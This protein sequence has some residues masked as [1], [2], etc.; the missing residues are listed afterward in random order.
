MAQFKSG[1]GIARTASCED[2]D[3]AL[4][5]ATNTLPIR[6]RNLPVGCTESVVAA[7]VKLPDLGVQALP[8]PFTLL[9]ENTYRCEGNTGLS[10]EI[11][12]DGLGLVTT[13]PDGWQR[14]ATP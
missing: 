3:L 12:A 8:Q 7:W 4:T 1:A 14:I 2:A 5:P 9:T 10:A 11:V 6:P 13:Y